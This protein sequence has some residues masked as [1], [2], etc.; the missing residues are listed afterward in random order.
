M[1]KTK[2]F[3]K[4]QM[5]MG[6]IGLG[7]KSA[8]PSKSHYFRKMSPNRA[9]PMVTGIRPFVATQTAPKTAMHYESVGFSSNYNVH[10]AKHFGGLKAAVVSKD[11]E[12]REANLSNLQ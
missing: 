4:E 12:H 8:K 3:S 5:V 10:N 1:V 2:E 6:N 11:E 9:S 7:L